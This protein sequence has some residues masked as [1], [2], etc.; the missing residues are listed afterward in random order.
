M[1]RHSVLKRQAGGIEHRQTDCR[2][3]I[4]A[5]NMA[6]GLRST[7]KRGRLPLLH[8]NFTANCLRQHIV[9]MNKNIMQAGNKRRRPHP[10]QPRRRI[11]LLTGDSNIID[12]NTKMLGK[13]TTHLHSRIDSAGGIL[14]C[15]IKTGTI[16][17]CGRHGGN[18][19]A[20]N[21]LRIPAWR[22]SRSTVE[23]RINNKF[24]H[25]DA[26]FPQHGF[27]MLRKILNAG[28]TMVET[29]LPFTRIRQGNVTIAT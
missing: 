25:S 27:C 13:R 1:G 18:G 8:R 11:R 10:P 3:T 22:H 16:H 6:Y 9:G 21:I 14:P 24:P 12:S 26:A 23:G 4:V 29:I 17:H 20:T 19:T 15:C 28:R 5:Q 2:N 7:S